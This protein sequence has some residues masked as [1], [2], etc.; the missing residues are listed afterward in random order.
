MLAPLKAYGSPSRIR[1]QQPFPTALNA[2]QPNQI[3]PLLPIFAYPHDQN[4]PSMSAS[5]HQTGLN[6]RGNISE[7][8][9]VPQQ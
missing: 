2:L 4:T 1:N 8:V 9:G 3:R 5:Y 7:A 6:G